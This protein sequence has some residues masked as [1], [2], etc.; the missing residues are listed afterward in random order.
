MSAIQ[1]QAP[2]GGSVVRIVSAFGRG[3]ASQLTPRMLAL[4]VVPFL[5][6]VGFW[7]LS[8][9]FL[10]DPVT[11]W[12][13][14][15][16]FQGDGWMAR[17]YRWASQYGLSGL[18]T[19]IPNLFAFLLLVPIAIATALALIAVL[20]MPVVIRHL[21]NRNYP[22]VARR[23]SLALGPNLWNVVRSL[24]V[25]VVGYLLTMPLW[26]IPPLALIVP[27][28]WWGWLTARLMRFDSLVEHADA[29]ERERLIR[30]DRRPYLL[31]GLGLALLNYIPP[32]FL[33]APV[34]S[35]LVFAHY[36]L[37][38]LREQRR[39]DAASGAAFEAAASVEALGVRK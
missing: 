22:D 5:V 10:W 34:L 26:L 12:F 18:S 36:S 15:L 25:F 19:W 13:Q 1:K 14:T 21:G 37:S 23:G 32:L 28:L 2:L 4:L 16:V 38:R 33:V 20:A 17:G 29:G 8:A 30:S 9:W 24:V 6:A 27:W 31:L 39:L 3:I 35:A 11:G 7:I